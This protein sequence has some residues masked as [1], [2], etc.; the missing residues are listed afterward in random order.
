MNYPVW[1]LTTFGG[2]LLV[3]LI[4]VFHV[5]LAHFA[6][7]GGLFLVLSEKKAVRENS[8]ALLDYTRKHAKFFMLLTMVAGGVTGVG[9]WFIIALL[10]PAGTSV[11][12]HTFVFGWATEWV[13]F[14][15]EI[16][17]LFLYFYKFDTMERKS[18]ITIGW[19]YFLFAWLSLVLITGIINFMLTP[20]EWTTDRSFWSGFFN[21]GFLPGVVFRSFLSFT[22]AGLFGLLTAS[23]LKD[24]QARDTMVRYCAKWVSLPILGLLLSGWWYFSVLPPTAREMIGGEAP[25]ILPFV[26]VFIWVLPILFLAGLVLMAKTVVLRKPVAVILVL[27][28][29]V[30]MGSFEWIRESARR[31]WIIY[32]HM[33]SNSFLKTDESRIMKQ[34]V[35]KTAKWVQNR[36][37][38]D[39]N[40]LAAGKE[41]F[42]LQC[43]SCHSIGGPNNDILPLTRKF[44]VFGMDSMLNGLGKLNQYMPRY[45]GTRQERLA[46][47][48]YIVNGLHGGK[49]VETAQQAKDLPFEIPPFDREK[50]EYVLLAWNNLG[51]HCLS[52]SDPWWILLPPANDLFA[53]LVKRGEAPE[54]VT[55]GVELTYEVESGFENPQRHVRFWDH[56]QSLFGLKEKLPEKIG[57]SG[58]PVTGGTMKLK[59]DHMAF[60]ASLVPVAPYPDDGSFNPYPIF[61][62][63]AREKKTGKVLA[64]TKMVAPTSTE[65]GCKNCLAGRCQSRQAAFVPE[66]PF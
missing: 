29:F 3:A 32:E 23:F 62:I 15:A 2:G 66:L 55:E 51:M 19:L 37:I 46:L 57:V 34:G 49:Q 39:K 16:I 35:L 60:E 17:A 61:T 38:N 4:A 21:P 33:Y 56:A 40:Q 59:E 41:L 63:T 26:R 5:T 24:E 22:I 43:S 30:Y 1:E 13:C 53:Q 10:Q 58:N 25:E 27:L 45:M 52:D 64:R 12:I 54:I 42:Y 7:G 18:H 9:I 6:V 31:P 47:A 44:T 14:L 48:S 65:M 36:E 20:G 50:D 11:L 28:G 8:F